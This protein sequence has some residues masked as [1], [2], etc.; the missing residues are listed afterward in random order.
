MAS[1]DWLEKDF[2]KILGVK[3]EASEDE[4]RKIYRKLA[5]QYHPDA[6]PGDKAAEER[7]K[8][9]SE[10]YSVLSDKQQREEYDALR[11]M[12]GGARFTAGGPGGGFEDVFSNL[13]GGGFPGAG[14]RGARTAG[15]PGARGGFS[16]FGAFGDFGSQRGSDFEASAN[17]SFFEALRGTTI[18][19]RLQEYREPIKL[20]VP[21]G[22]QSGKRLKVSGKGQKSVTGGQAGDLYVKV[23]VKPHPVFSRDGDDIRIRVPVTVAEAVLGATITVPTP[24][25][26]TVKLKIAAGTPNGRVLRVKDQGV[27]RGGKQGDLLVTLEVAIPAHV[28]ERAAELI[29]EFDKALPDE[30]PRAELLARAKQPEE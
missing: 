4:L 7:F 12:G 25:G 16:P 14:A 5:R 8:E 24:E 29:A 21:A 2:Y 1:Q 28:N 19:L 22:F 13:F 27:K 6:N 17:I 23:R 18:S 9:I 30:D 10:A 3:K 11:A 20:K 26:E 15:F